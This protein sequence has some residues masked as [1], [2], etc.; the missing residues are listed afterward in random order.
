M[1]VDLSGI[2]LDIDYDAN[3]DSDIATG[4]VDDQVTI[5][6]LEA[7]LA[8]LAR[9]I[10][11]LQANLDDVRQDRDTWQA[12]A[13]ALTRAM[14]QSQ[15]L[16]EAHTSPPETAPDRTETERKPRRWWWPWSG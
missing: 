5:A 10:T 1:Y 11:R 9:E 4:K 15:K 6:R 3:I 7:E 2:D 12:Q 13:A 14:D 16:L 8:G